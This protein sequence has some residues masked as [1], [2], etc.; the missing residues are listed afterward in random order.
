MPNSG[1]SLLNNGTIQ[2]IQDQGSAKE[3]K[4]GREIN[5]IPRTGID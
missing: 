5:L 4:N 2:T 3:S 1:N